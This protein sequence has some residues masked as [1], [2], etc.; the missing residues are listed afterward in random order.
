[1][2]PQIPQYMTNLNLN[3]RPFRF[4]ENYDTSIAGEANTYN[5]IWAESCYL[6]GNKIVYI[7][8]TIHNPEPIFGEYLGSV[9]STGTEMYFFND[10]L[11]QG[12]WGGSGDLYSKF[13]LTVTDTSTWYCPK[14]MF[15][16]AKQNPLYDGTNTQFL[17]F[18]PKVG[19]LIYYSI[20]K[21]LFEIDHIENEASPGMFIFGNRNS[22]VFKTKVFAYDHTQIDQTSTTIPD[23]IKALDK[24][25]NINGTN[26]DVLPKQ[27][28]TIF[29]QPIRDAASS[30][31]IKTEKDP[32]G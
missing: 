2:E 16:Q 25:L 5:N 6:H 23:E 24:I 28:D 30:I 21:K 31:V 4:N 18:Y 12:A 27:E 14:L 10:E 29:N 20:S 22:Y 3:S 1:M 13:G 8:R 7:E 17:P 32:L 11:T 26:V 9:L 19:D 15:T